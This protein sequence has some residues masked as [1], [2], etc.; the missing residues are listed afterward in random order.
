MERI[1]VQTTGGSGDD[2]VGASPS[3][4]GGFPLAFGSSALMRGRIDRVDDTVT[5]TLIGEF[6]RLARDTFAAAMV[7]IEKTNPHRIVVNVQ[8]LAF[9]DST[10]TR[11]LFDAHRRASGVRTFAVLNGSGPAHRT[12]QL[13]GLDKVLIMVDNPSQLTGVNTQ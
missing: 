5:L 2:F 13:A 11:Q 12:L 7:A 1:V 8:G 9:M 4:P 6:D 3:R 10:G